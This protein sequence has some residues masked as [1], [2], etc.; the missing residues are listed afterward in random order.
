MGR[1]G[2]GRACIRESRANLAPP[3]AQNNHACII[4]SPNLPRAETAGLGVGR[5]NA[6]VR[7]PRLSRSRVTIQTVIFRALRAHDES[8]TAFSPPARRT[9]ECRPRSRRWGHLSRFPACSRSWPR[10]RRCSPR[11]RYAEP[12]VF[13]LPDASSQFSSQVVAP[14]SLRLRTPRILSMRRWTA[15][16][17]LADCVTREYRRDGGLSRG[18]PRRSPDGTSHNVVVMTAEVSK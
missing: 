1:G 5:F 15:R 3:H 11:T 8:F 12:S 7:I 13:G 14:K 17:R 9:P 10:S 18:E 4:I 2:R 6:C 16:E